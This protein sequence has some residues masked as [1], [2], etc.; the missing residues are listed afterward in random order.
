MC[1]LLLPPA[2]VFFVYYF[3]AQ[4]QLVFSPSDLQDIHGV[5]AALALLIAYVAH[6]LLW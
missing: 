2:L 1:L 6:L 5:S 3:Q 4:H